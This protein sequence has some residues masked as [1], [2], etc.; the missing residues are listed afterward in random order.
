MGRLAKGIYYGLQR[1]RRGVTDR[2]VREASGL[3]DSPWREVEAYVGRRLEDNYD[4]GDAGG[5]QWLRDQ[6][7]RTRQGYGGAGRSHSLPLASSI[8][9][10]TSGSSGKPFRFRRD[11]TMLA[12]MDAAMWAAYS[13]HGVEPGD[14]MARFWGRPLSGSDRVKRGIADGLLRQ[15]RMSAFEVSPERSR[16]FYDDLVDWDPQWA[17]GYP[18][19]MREFVEHLRGSGKAGGRLGLEV[20]ITTGEL[21]DRSTRTALGEYFE[22]PVVDEY[23]CS[24]SGILSFECEEGRSHL[25]PVAAYAEIQDGTAA[26]DESI[27][28]G[29][30]LVTDLYGDAMPFVRYRLD[31]VARLHPPE[32]CSCGRELPRLEILS[33]RAD[34]FIRTPRG[35]KIYDAVLAYSVPSGVAEFQVRQTELDRLQGRVV[36]AEGRDERDVLEQCRARWREAVGGGVQVE[37]TAVERIDRDSSGKFRYFVPL[38]DGEHGRE[39]PES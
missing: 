14:R 19:L 30:V 17:Y 36:V 23:G 6:P 29:P 5:L 27:P 8:V 2:M 31:D 11:R 21:L 28:E 10:R 35:E 20:V 22:C 7:V 37:V 18:T 25:L 24:E 38:E 34:S 26:V 12:W 13:W 1:L 15:R 16:A 39:R 3:L 9:R 4:V 33:G 32:E